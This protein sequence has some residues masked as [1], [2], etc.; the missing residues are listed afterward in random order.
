MKYTAPAPTL[1][2][3]LAALPLVKSPL[4]WRI[5]LYPKPYN[6]SGS[7]NCVELVYTRPDSSTFVWRRWGA[8]PKTQTSDS[9]MRALL[10]AAQEA[11]WYVESIDEDT[12]VKRVRWDIDMIRRG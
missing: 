4:V 12:L 8:T 2:D 10:L 3:I 5:A 9:V 11:Y 7:H 1:R 6:S